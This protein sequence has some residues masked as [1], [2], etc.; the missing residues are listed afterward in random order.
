MRDS[1]KSCR[2]VKEDED[3]DEAI[4]ASSRRAFVILIRAVS[5]LWWVLKPDWR[6][7]KSSW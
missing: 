5:V 1:I 2:K 4:V 7:S 3:G 6:G